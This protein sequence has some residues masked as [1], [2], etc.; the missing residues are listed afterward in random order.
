MGGAIIIG[1]VFFMVL[2]SIFL[3]KFGF[4]NNSLLNQQETYLSLFTLATV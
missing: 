3:Q 4:T 1:S 2:L